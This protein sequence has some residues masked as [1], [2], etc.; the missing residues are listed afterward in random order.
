MIGREECWA[1]ER[2]FCPYLE[3]YI[4][5]AHNGHHNTL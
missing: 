5:K 4:K 2:P 3:K 1:V